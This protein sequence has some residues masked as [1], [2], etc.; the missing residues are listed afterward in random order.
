MPTPAP[1]AIEGFEEDDES[2]HIGGSLDEFGSVGGVAVDETV[3]VAVEETVNVAVEE[4]LMVVV[5]LLLGEV[6]PDVRLNITFPAW[7]GNGAVLPRV[8]A[9]HALVD[10][11]PGPQQK[12][13]SSW[14]G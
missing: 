3:T 6:E 13:V 1:T 14:K 8:L 2:V 10:E 7:T 12:A 9:I 4:S 11:L 5:S